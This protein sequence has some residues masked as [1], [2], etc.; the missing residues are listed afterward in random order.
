MSLA[1]PR[2]V[3]FSDSILSQNSPTEL[4]T[5]YGFQKYNALKI[6]RYMQTKKT[7]YITGVTDNFKWLHTS[8][9]MV[10]N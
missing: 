7:Y 3:I 2:T 5:I 1:T 9:V 6:K 8:P 10:V 4:K